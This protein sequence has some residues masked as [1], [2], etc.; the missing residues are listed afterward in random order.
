MF[1]LSILFQRYTS[2]YQEPTSEHLSCYD[3]YFNRHFFTLEASQSE[4]Q[5]WLV[6]PSD[7]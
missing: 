5:I 3:F 2:F 7:F 1:L 4:I 6:L